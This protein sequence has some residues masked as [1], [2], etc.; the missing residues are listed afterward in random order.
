MFLENFLSAIKFK[1]LC[2]VYEDEYL[3]SLD[4]ENFVQV[5]RVFQKY[6]FYFIEDIILN[7]L[8]IFTLDPK[9]VEDEII[10]LKNVLGANFIYIIG[11]DMRYL[12]K[13]LG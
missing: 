11:H 4:D 10:L 9:Y 1:M 12:E 2:D 8:D 7:Y 5:Y 6:N 3:E 13:M